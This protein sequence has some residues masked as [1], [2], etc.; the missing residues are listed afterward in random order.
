MLPLYKATRMVIGEIFTGVYLGEAYL[1][2]GRLP[3][4]RIALEAV[5]EHAERIGMRYY[6]G[7]ALRLLAEV[8]RQDPSPEGRD[9]ARRY[10]ERSIEV[11]DAIGAENELALAY[12]GYGEL[13]QDQ[14]YLQRALEI[15]ERLGTASESERV[16]S[17][18]TSPSQG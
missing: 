1:C 13:R 4:A 10:F 14:S 2:A 7:W 12:A 9:R 3:E 17:S 8:A 16:R 18:S 5:A 11:L 6:F 15:F